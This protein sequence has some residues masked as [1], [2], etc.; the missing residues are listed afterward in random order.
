MS[1]IFPPGLLDIAFDL[2]EFLLRHNGDRG[3]RD[4][5]RERRSR[6]RD[7]CDGV[8]FQRQITLTAVRAHRAVILSSGLED[9]PCIFEVSMPTLVQA[10]V[11]KL[12]IEALDEG[13]LHRLPGSMKCDATASA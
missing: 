8:L 11:A 3:D 5:R 4:D 10:F 7:G 12:S 1:R 9:S 13:V 6:S 2:S